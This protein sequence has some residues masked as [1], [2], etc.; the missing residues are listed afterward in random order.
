MFCWK[1]YKLEVNIFGSS[2]A[3]EIGVEMHGFP[4][5][6]FSSEELQQ[7]LDLRRGGKSYATLRKESDVPSFVGADGGVLQPFVRAVLKNSDVCTEDYSE[8]F[9]KPRPSHAD[10]AVYCKDGRLDFSGGGEFSGRMTAPLCIAGGIAKQLLEKRGIDV[11][12]YVSSVGKAQGFSYKK[13]NVLPCQREKD[14]PSVAGSEQ[15]LRE[16]FNAK[17]NGDSVGGIVECVVS[18]VT[19]GVGG[20]LFEGLEGKLSTLLFAIPAV[21]GVEFGDGFDLAQSCGSQSNDELRIQNDK[22]TFLSN[23]SGGINGGISNGMPI[24]M[25]VAFRPTP[26][27]AKKQNTVDLVS[28][29]NTEIEISGRHDPCVVPRAV[30]VVEA[31]VSLVV[32]DEILFAE[33]KHD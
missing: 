23:K 8:L 17:Q 22:V 24:T 3:E 9:G 31:A 2:H 26:S 15:M 1:G 28:R 33:Q 21:K 18:G 5:E 20:A 25:A 6:S 11:F 19:P 10:Y 16:I 29:Q 32:L 30:P 7:L 13:S 12:A 14:F 4:S 27:I